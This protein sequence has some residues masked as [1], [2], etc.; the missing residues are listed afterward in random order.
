MATSSAADKA[1]NEGVMI[2]RA[3]AIWIFAGAGEV[4]AAASLPVTFG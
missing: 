2:I 4:A 1:A 3:P